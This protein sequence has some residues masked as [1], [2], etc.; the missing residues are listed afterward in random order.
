MVNK[1]Q[2][3]RF[4]KLCA[5]DEWVMPQLGEY[6][7]AMWLALF[8]GGLT[9]FAAVALMFVSGYL[10]SKAATKPTNIL[11]I[12]V[13]IVLT[14]AFGIG[15][16]SFKYAERLVSHN[17]VLKMTSKLRLKLYLSLISQQR[18]LKNSPAV[19]EMMTLMAQDINHI[20]DLYLK[21]IF[22]AVVAWLLYI[23]LVCGLGGFNLLLAAGVFFIF[24][25]M[26]A[27]IPLVALMSN[28][29]LVRRL[30]FYKNALYQDLCDNI[31]GVADWIFAGRSADYLRRYAA[32]E[33]KA[34]KLDQK[35]ARR[36]NQRNFWLQ[37]LGLVAVIMI[38]VIA[39]GILGHTQASRNAIAAFVLATF[40]LIDAFSPTA[41]ALQSLPEYSDSILRLNQ[42]P[43]VSLQTPDKKITTNHPAIEL[44]NVE[45]TYHAGSPKVLSQLSLTIPFGQKIALLGRSGA[46]KSTLANLILGINSPTSG[47]VTIAGVPSS[48]LKMS[49]IC[50]VVSQRPYLFNTTVRNNLLLANEAASEEQLWQALAKVGLAQKIRQ[51][52][53]QLD[54]I[55][56]QAGVSFSG[57]EQHRIALARVLLKDTPIVLLDE[58]TVG[59]DP[60]IEASL[61]EVFMQTLADKTVIW[62]THH[63]QSIE[64]ADCVVFLADGKITV[65]GT[66]QSLMKTSPM[67][68]QLVALDRGQF[69]E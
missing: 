58:P 43:Q 36:Q 24:L 5:N 22:P 67:Y 34:D 4:F 59:L 14:R 68:Q 64:L 3:H 66:P 54:T 69:D 39:S 52:P 57:G 28:A 33:Q 1:R 53:K 15:R 2:L 32:S 50:S 60:V 51:L 25:V 29:P 42:L 61:L 8:L 38:L 55:I 49:D 13:P 37:A 7:V 27:V 31:L 23:V 62:I 44:K 46:G 63:L 47:Q 10:I 26:V 19:S 17:W 45:F 41:A 65:S 56:G 12:Y 20:Q 40:P 35:L 16:P 21:V 48:Q 9:F 30:K 11:L 18:S 6:K